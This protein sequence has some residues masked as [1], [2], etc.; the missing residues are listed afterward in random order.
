MEHLLMQSSNGVGLFGV[1]NIL[2][3][4]LLLNLERLTV[5]GIPYQLLNM[6]GACCILFSLFYHWNLSSAV[7]EVA[8]IMISLLGIYR[9]YYSSHK[10]CDE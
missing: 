4:F 3:A 2:L 7:I 5:N 6:V 9:R 1:V 8:C 10:N